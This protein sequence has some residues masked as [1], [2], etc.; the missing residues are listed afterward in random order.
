MYY[1]VLSWRLQS[2][3]SRRKLSVPLLPCRKQSIAPSLLNRLSSRFSI[4]NR[5]ARLSTNWGLPDAL[6]KL[7]LV[8]PHATVLSALSQ[9][10]LRQSNAAA[11]RSGQA[12]T[13]AQPSRPLVQ[14]SSAAQDTFDQADIVAEPCDQAAEELRQAND[15]AAEELQDEA[16]QSVSSE[17]T[18]PTV[19][20]SS[21][22]TA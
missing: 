10:L 21:R 3:V 2:G 15:T 6:Q 19:L 13:S 8:E 12:D 17:G 14:Q 11:N 18:Y 16:S 7:G 9:P 1:A 4:G 20:L 5:L 22:V